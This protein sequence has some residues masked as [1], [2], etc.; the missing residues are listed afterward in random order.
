MKIPH[1]LEDL[2][3]AT[4]VE[5]LI[6][7]LQQPGLSSRLKETLNRVGLGE[8]NPLEQVQK[9]WQQ[10]RSWIESVASEGI[11]PND[12]E[13]INASGNWLDPRFA[14]VPISTTIAQIVANHA[15][16]HRLREA[17]QARVRELSLQLFPDSASGFANS[18]L[19]ALQA[20]TQGKRILVAKHELVKLEGIGNLSAM[21]RHLDVLEIGAANG[22][23]DQDYRTAFEEMNRQE[24]VL[25]TISPLQRESPDAT[26]HLQRLVGLRSSGIEIIGLIADA[27]QSEELARRYG[28]PQIKDLA[29]S[30]IDAWISPLDLLLGGPTGAMLAGRSA[31]IDSA[32]KRL[33]AQGNALSLACQQAA[34]TALQLGDLG[35][36]ALTG[37]SGPLLV[38]PE[39]LQERARRIAIQ[40]NDTPLVSSAKE[41]RME[42]AL[43]AAPWDR[44]R[45]VNWGVRITPREDVAK[46]EAMLRK[47][48]YDAGETILPP[49]VC[50]RED[51]DL[52]VDLRFVAPKDDHLIVRALSSPEMFSDV[53]EGSSTAT[54]EADSPKE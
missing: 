50:R 28:F 25:L 8:P 6:E 41:Q 36:D 13:A 51:N 24:S 39:V 44:Y 12:S 37:G 1:R 14:A 3:P 10:A 23:D 20:L 5:N 42:R 34:L 22:C 47:G 49:I 30:G 9:A 7:L 21:L 29:E 32:V 2:Y 31:L 15:S 18:V 4:A 46:S 17:G 54:A 19:S 43:A 53:S 26:K 48:S 11:I 52:F 27:V 35:D 45:M 33:T 40:L 38:N 16:K